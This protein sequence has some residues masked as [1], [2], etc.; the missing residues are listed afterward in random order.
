MGGDTV[1]KPPLIMSKFS[2]ISFIYSTVINI[3]R[4]RF[5]LPYIFKLLVIH[6]ILPIQKVITKMNTS[7]IH[8]MY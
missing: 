4:Q 8:L 1:F 3:C 7:I 2:D 5:Y 6:T